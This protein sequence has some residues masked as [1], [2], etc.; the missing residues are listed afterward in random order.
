MHRRTFIA[1]AGAI[2]LL[3]ICA[4]AVYAF[5]ASRDDLIAGGVTIGGVDAG[6]MRAGEARE[7]VERELAAPVRRP[8]VVRVDGRRFSLT[9]RQARVTVDVEG[10]VQ[11]ALAAS[12]EGN[13]LTRTFRS[14]TGRDTDARV[15]LKVSWSRDAVAR[16]VRRV[17]RGVDRK[18]SDARVSYSGAGLDKVPHKNGL[19]VRGRELERSINA[20]LA[21]PAADRVVAAR[22]K[23]TKPQITTDELAAKYPSFIIVN[24][25]R[26]QLRYYRNL[27]LVETYKIAVGQ[28]GLETP[29][30]L[31]RIQNKAVNPTWNVPNSDWAGELAGKVIP[32][33][34]DNPLKARWMGIYD[35]AGI[36]GTD[37]ISS[38]GTN[39]SHGC[40]RMSIPDVKELYDRVDLQTPV[41]IA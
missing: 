36:H 7:V 23:V 39:A 25:G 15:E 28:V 12:R 30:G 34:P 33:G 19:A 40:I 35:G 4:A 31:Y 17:K 9:A 6:G 26:F 20:E 2:A 10:M 29:A 22:T 32:P 8:L 37:A 3:L 18:P 14:V 13:A 21:D 1:L 5:D 41:F 11:E 24:R 38:L 27:E 16:L